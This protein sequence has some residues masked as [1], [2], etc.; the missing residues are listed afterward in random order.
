MKFTTSFITFGFLPRLH[1]LIEPEPNTLTDVALAS[2][3]EPAAVAPTTTFHSASEVPASFASNLSLLE[4]RLGLQAGTVKIDGRSGKPVSLELREPIL[5]GDGV[6]NH[7]LWSVGGGY[8]APGSQ[9]EWAEMSVT[10]VK[11]RLNLI[12]YYLSQNTSHISYLMVYLN[13]S[14]SRLFRTG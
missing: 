7:L 10:A 1:A 6:G 11:V 13:Y 8:D 4:D 2:F 12:H 14:L 5:P 9:E 3:V